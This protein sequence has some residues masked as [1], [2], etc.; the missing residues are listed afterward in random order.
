MRSLDNEECLRRLG[1]ETEEE[2]GEDTKEKEYLREVKGLEKRV[3]LRE[4]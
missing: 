3:V 2:E 1:R 4:S